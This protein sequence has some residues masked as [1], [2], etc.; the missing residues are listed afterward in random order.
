MSTKSYFEVLGVGRAFHLDERELEARYLSLS[1]QLHPDRHARAT[2]HERLVAVTRTTELNDAYRVLK[3]PVKRAEYLLKLE[4][5]DVA[6]EKS[7]SVKP[8]PALLMDMME[9]NEA[10][11]E[12]RAAADA[13]Q[14]RQIAADVERERARA[15]AAVD[16]GFHGYDCGDRST[17]PAIA[18]ALIALRYHARLLEQ[19]EA[20]AERSEA[21]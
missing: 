9:R 16:A 3:Q 10:L 12:A 4:G 6:D 19:I 20:V 13:A 15:L 18:Q 11:A 8:D 5:I 7:A 1:K 14:V 17:L 21:R 2:P